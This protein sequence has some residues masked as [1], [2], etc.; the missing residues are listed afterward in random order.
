M[1]KEHLCLLDLS[2]SPQVKRLQNGN[3]E[4]SKHRTRNRSPYSNL[5]FLKDPAAP[6]GRL[7]VHNKAAHAGGVDGEA[8]ARF[9]AAAD[10]AKVTDS[11]GAECV[12]G[13][14][15]G[16]KEDFPTRDDLGAQKVDG[17]KGPCSAEL[18]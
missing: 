4:E 14:V 17:A 5:T 3:V 9:A 13:R 18:L 6:F 10:A 12:G 7:V 16:A 2:A 1:K 11:G 15:G 8:T